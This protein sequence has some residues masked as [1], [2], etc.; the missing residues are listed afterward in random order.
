M[1]TPEL[2][3]QWVWKVVRDNPLQCPSEARLRHQILEK[4]IQPSSPPYSLP[5]F[6]KASLSEH[7]QDHPVKGKDGRHVLLHFSCPPTTY[8]DPLRGYAKQ[9]CIHPPHL[10]EVQSPTLHG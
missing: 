2:F 9:L 3:A 10:V 6:E 4:A 1:F 7:H 5:D 8:Q